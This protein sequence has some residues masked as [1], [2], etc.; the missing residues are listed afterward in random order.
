MLKSNSAVREIPMSY[1]KRQVDSLWQENHHLPGPSVRDPVVVVAVDF[2]KHNRTRC[3]GVH[4]LPTED[5]YRFLAGES[6]TII[7]ANASLHIVLVKRLHPGNGLPPD[8]SPDFK[9]SSR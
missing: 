9:D 7:K 4:Q 5:Q 3:L 2:V 8:P 1:R 6:V